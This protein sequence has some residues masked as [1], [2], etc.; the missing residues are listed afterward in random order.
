MDD[1]VVLDAGPLVALLDKSDSRHK[2]AS[3]RIHEFTGRMLT[4]DAVLSEALFLVRAL[5][6][7]VTQVHRW[8]DGGLVEPAFSS[9]GET[10]AIFSLMRRYANVPMSFADACL[11]RMSEL[12][13]RARVF[14]LDADFR[15]YRRNGRQVIP[16]ICP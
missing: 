2:W 3:D 4:C 16:L 10:N 11:V 5:P 12:W 14:T 1:V 15:I 8:I 13:T 6:P 9:A 7:A